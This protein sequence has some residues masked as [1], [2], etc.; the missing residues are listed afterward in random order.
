MA[1]AQGAALAIAVS[2]AGGLGS[3]PCAHADARRD[4]QGAGCDPG[5]TRPAVQRQFLLPCAARA[6][7]ARE[8]AWRAA[9]APYYQQFGID[10]AASQP[11]RD[12]RRSAP[13]AADVLEEFKPAVVSFH[14]GLPPADLLARVQVL[15][16]EDPLFGDHRR[17][18]ALAGSARRRCGHRA[19]PGGGRPSRH[20]PVRRPEHAGRHFRAAAA[21]RACGEGAGDRRRRHRRR[22]G[23]RGGDGAGRRGRAG[24]HRLSAVPGGDHQRRAPRGAE[25]RSGTPHRADQPLHRAAG[26]RHRQPG[27]ARARARSAACRPRSRW[28]RRR[29]RRC[30]PRPRPGQRRFLAAVVRP[31]RDRLPG[32]P[33]RASSR[34]RSPR[35]C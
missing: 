24:R 16:R 4:A 18:G 20:L 35:A 13:E 26:A 11:A 23:R 17:R 15:G 33:G 32:N 8:A 9:L 1:G 19:G 21:G 27:H 10:P 3:L 28:R 12:A 7:A 25:E 30:A 2:N 29:S 5:A 14:F 22:E 34:R 6:D 31:E